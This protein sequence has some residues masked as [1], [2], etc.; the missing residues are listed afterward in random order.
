MI[1]VSSRSTSLYLLRFPPPTQRR[2]ISLTAS[3]RMPRKA[4]SKVHL[5]QPIPDNHF[6]RGYIAS[7]VHAGV[8][9]KEGVLDLGVLISTS[10]QTS[11]AACFTRNAFKAAPVQVST[12]VLNISGG[13]ARALVV[14]SGCANAVTGVRGMENAWTMVAKTDALAREVTQ[15][16]GKYETLVMSTGV[17]GQH[18]P[19]DKITTALSGDDL[20]SGLGFSFGYWEGLAH[21]FMTT[22]TFP[23][24]RARKFN[25]RG[26]DVRI[27]GIDKGAGMIHPN[28][29]PP[30]KLSIY[31]CIYLTLWDLP[32]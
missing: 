13:R 29:G 14:N 30:G 21:A 11:G 5:H 16:G 12:E 15:S 6:P 2:S 17:I 3:L 26:K 25:L 7:S 18:L 8:K 24:L 9:K 23:K 32:S 20:K 22:D 27:A 4:P 28:M 10:P 1:L 19:I 31:A